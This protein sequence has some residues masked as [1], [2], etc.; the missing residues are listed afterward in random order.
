M[1]KYNYKLV[2]TDTGQV[3]YFVEYRNAEHNYL[4][5]KKKGHTV[6]LITLV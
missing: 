5:E 6:E 2:L 1:T 3:F 4:V